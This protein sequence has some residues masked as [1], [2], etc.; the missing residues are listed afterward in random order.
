[1][2]VNQGRACLKTSKYGGW[3]L[4]F[5]CLISAALRLRHRVREPL[6]P[7]RPVLARD[8]DAAVTRRRAGP[9]GKH[10]RGHVPAVGFDF[11]YID[12][13]IIIIVIIWIF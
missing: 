9:V 8:D 1:M 4:C 10:G 6:V 7:E 13:I 12:I 11:F 5:V 2:A 3:D